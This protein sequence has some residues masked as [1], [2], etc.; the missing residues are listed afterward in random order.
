MVD[1]N[2]IATHG[3][4]DSFVCSKIDGVSRSWFGQTTK[5]DHGS[6]LD[7][8]APTMTLDMPRH[9]LKK[10]SVRAMWKVFRITLEEAGVMLGLRICIRVC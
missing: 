4:L 9:K 1:T 6:N 5:A 2:L 3:M 10:P 7:I 8:P